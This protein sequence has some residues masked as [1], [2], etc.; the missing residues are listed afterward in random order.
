MYM[1][2]ANL[3]A[4]LGISKPADMGF[5]ITHINLHKTFSTPHGGGGPGAGP[6]AVI[7]KL[8]EFLP[9]P[10]I[11]KN[12]D[13]FS[14]DYDLPHS[15]GSLHTFYGNFLVLVRAYCYIMSLGD[16]GLER[17]S[18]VAILNANFLKSKLKN[19]YEIPYEDGIM[20]EFVISAIS[21]KNRGIKALDI[22]KSLLDYGYH[23]LTTIYFPTNVPEAM[24][25]EPTESENIDTL[26]S[27]AHSM[28]EIDS[29]IDS[30]PESI[31]NAPTKTPIGRLNETKANRE[32]DINYY[33]K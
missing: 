20:H 21:Q 25:I 13:Y 31:L 15:I 27:F 9:I 14:F 11:K 5:D 26:E 18:K 32:P 6:I 1:D 16:S 23:S 22:A 33:N 24:M 29:R 8:A 12:K 30:N 7:K 17:M 19:V 3:N 4:L 2:G 10:R 28:I